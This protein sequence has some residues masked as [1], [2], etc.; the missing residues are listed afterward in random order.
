MTITIEATE[1]RNHTK[2]NNT[3]DV[4]MKFL[5]I[6]DSTSNVR[7]QINTKKKTLNIFFRRNVHGE[8][9]RR[10]T[11]LFFKTRLTDNGT[12]RPYLKF[13]AY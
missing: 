1:K 3:T 11:V 13:C 10:V 5:L 9:N 12:F 2:S 6:I 4:Q 8:I 7:I